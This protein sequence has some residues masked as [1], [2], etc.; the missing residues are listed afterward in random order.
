[1]AQM[2]VDWS[3]RDPFHLNNEQLGWDL[4]EQ[5]ICE[6][7][8]RYREERKI[9][10]ELDFYLEACKYQKAEG[11]R[12]RK[13]MFHKPNFI[14][15]IKDKWNAFLFL[16]SRERRMFIAVERQIAMAKVE[17]ERHEQQMN[18]IKK[19]NEE[20]YKYAK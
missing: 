9:K 19:L 1:M 4:V 6:S 13:A 20:K 3:E 18:E 8:K 11:I 12:E 2:H 10:E 5:D 16:I 15:A 17:K 14:D 7:Q